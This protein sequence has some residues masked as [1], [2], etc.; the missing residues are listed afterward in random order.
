MDNSSKK[1]LICEICGITNEDGRFIYTANN[2]FKM[3]LCKNHYGQ[4]RNHGKILAPTPS[5][6]NQRLKNEYI[7]YDDYAEICLYDRYGKEFARTQIDIDKIDIC[8]KY[9]WYGKPKE[10]GIYV[11]SKIKNKGIWLHRLII[12]AQDGKI[13]DH[14]DRNPL[15]NQMSNLR[16]CTNLENAHNR[17][18]P[19]T[20]KSGYLGVRWVKN[21]NKWIA[22]IRYNN[23]SIH[24]GYFTDVNDAIKARKEAELKYF[25]EFAPIHNDTE[26]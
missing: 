3:I 25:G 18:M 14:I 20:N 5:L 15:N 1:L 4:L 6:R 8:N 2:K 10:N 22:Q 7:I 23:K 12:D 24:L 9:K 16:I 26:K 17:S 11:M 19:I 13:V 21:S